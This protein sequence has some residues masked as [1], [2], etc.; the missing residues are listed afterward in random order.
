MSL[1]DPIGDFLTGIRNAVQAKKE[2]VTLPSSKLK[3][4]ICEI[5]KDEGFIRNFKV[6]EDD[7]KKSVRIHLKYLKNNRPAI[8]NLQRVSRPSLRRYVASKKIPRVYNGLG[9]V[10]LSTS[11]GVVT[12]THARKEHIGGE[13][14]CKVW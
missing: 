5:L 12:D 7:N 6:M 3:E 1:S 9:V 13:M 14:L 4:R 8:R 10:I 11:R 2:T